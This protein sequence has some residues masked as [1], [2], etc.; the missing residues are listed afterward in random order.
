[1]K[2]RLLII[3]WAILLILPVGATLHHLTNGEGLKPAPVEAQAADNGNPYSSKQIHQEDA[4]SL[5]TRIKIIV[6]DLL[7]KLGIDEEFA[8]Y[9]ATW[10]VGA[11]TLVIVILLAMI[12][13]PRRKKITPAQ[14][15][16]SEAVVPPKASRVP[17]N[18]ARRE[19]ATAT[20]KERILKFFFHL[21]KQQVAAEPDALS[22]IKLVETRPICPNETYEM[23]IQQGN[24]WASRRMSI[25]LLGQGG[26]SRSKCFYVIYDSHMVLKLP[27]ESIQGFS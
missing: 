19:P 18:R 8:K 11:P 23:R 6:R 12:F 27:A 15:Q 22:E 7:A 1:M 10:V 25:G 2:R 16:R 5:T 13:R 17:A 9:Y 14:V 24:D 21:F 20:D 3:A 26:G 4:Q